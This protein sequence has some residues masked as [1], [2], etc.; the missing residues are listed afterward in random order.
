[1]TGD[2]WE[3]FCEFLHFVHGLLDSLANSLPSGA[4]S[5]QKLLA[6]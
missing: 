4:T 2:N 3:F 6:A 1:V 5:F